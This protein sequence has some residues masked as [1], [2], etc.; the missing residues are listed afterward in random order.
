[1][2]RGR[3]PSLAPIS[4]IRSPRCQGTSTDKAAQRAAIGAEASAA[5]T[6]RFAAVESDVNPELRELPARQP[7]PRVR[8]HGRDPMATVTRAFIDFTDEAAVRAACCVLQTGRSLHDPGHGNGASMLFNRVLTPGKTHRH[9]SSTRPR[10]RGLA[11]I[12]RSRRP[13]T[14]PDR[15]PPSVSSLLRGRPTSSR[16]GD[17]V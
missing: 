13:A 15:P 2:R 3:G 14:S 9:R 12:L 5:K 4:P 1:M 6:V 11:R 16:R 7:P 8:T 10:P 17:C